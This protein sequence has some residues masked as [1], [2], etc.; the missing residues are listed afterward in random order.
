M[1]SPSAWVTSLAARGPLR[2]TWRDF[3]AS[4]V[5]KWVSVSDRQTD[6]G[7]GGEDPGPPPQPPFP[8]TPVPALTKHFISGPK[9]LVRSPGGS[10]RADLEP[11]ADS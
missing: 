2:A 10:G 9:V 8:Y 5:G 11:A 3:P 6:S 1:K 7:Q 4:L